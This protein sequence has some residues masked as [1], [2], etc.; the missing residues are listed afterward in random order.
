M[1][2]RYL[3]LEGIDGAGTSTLL[4]GLKATLESMGKTV[5]CAAQPSDHGAGILAR[6]YLKQ[7]LHEEFERAALALCFATDRLELRRDFEAAMARG[8]W[9]VCDR[10]VLSSLVYQGSELDE[11]WVASINRFALAADLT[12]LLDLPAQE[13]WG[14]ISARGGERERFEV[15]DTLGVLR[16]R[17][18]DAARTF[19]SPVRLIDATQ[20]PS[21]VLEAVLRALRE[22]GWLD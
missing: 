1:I 18:L 8:E 20:T 9:V 16:Q 11:D 14:R 5:Y 12:F 4:E 2:G 10:S 21:E 17:Y 22:R 15:L 3:V 6:G 13:A 7:P 19:A